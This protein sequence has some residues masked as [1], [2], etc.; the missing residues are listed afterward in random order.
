MLSRTVDL[1]RAAAKALESPAVADV[2]GF[3]DE[4]AFRRVRG[5]PARMTRVPIDA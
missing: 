4:S 3:G 5:R 2:L 1:L